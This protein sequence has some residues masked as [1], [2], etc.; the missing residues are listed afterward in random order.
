[1]NGMAKQYARSGFKFSGRD[2][3]NLYGLC[4]SDS[5]VVFIEGSHPA[6][7][8]SIIVTSQSEEENIIEGVPCASI[9]KSLLDFMHYPYDDSAI[10]ET[11][12]YMS[13]QELN[14]FKTYANGNNVLRDK[15][16][17]EFFE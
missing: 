17:Y 5:S 2:A 9:N 14:D 6:E 12:E 7:Y 8:Q 3:L 4:S 16:W 1:M 13:E 15:R 11:L 10:L